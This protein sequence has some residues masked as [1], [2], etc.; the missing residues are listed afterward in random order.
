MQ[1]RAAGPAVEAIWQDYRA[2]QR[3]QIL[4]LECWQTT[5]PAAPAIQQFIAGTQS[6]DAVRLLD[7]QFLFDLLQRGAGR[8]A[9]A[10]RIVDINETPQTDQAIVTGREQ[11][12]SIS[13][14]LERAN[15]KSMRGA[16]T[17]FTS[18]PQIVQ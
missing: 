14:K 12:S 1:C 3:F 5:P 9:I 11:E 6:R 2:T 16:L 4:G 17:D 15:G 10:Q 7:D 18:G 13:G 8:T